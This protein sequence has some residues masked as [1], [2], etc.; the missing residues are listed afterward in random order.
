VKDLSWLDLAA[1]DG[2]EDEFA[3]ILEE[4]IVSSSISE[5]RNTRLCIALRKRIELLREIVNKQIHSD[6]KR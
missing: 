6:A 3:S 2:I 1:L 4:T 5:E